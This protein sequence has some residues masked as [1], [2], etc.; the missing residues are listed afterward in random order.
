[1]PSY[2]S[3]G[4]VDDGVR[5]LL[6]VVRVIPPFLCRSSQIFLFRNYGDEYPPT[7]YVFGDELRG[8]LK[9]ITRA[10]RAAVLPAHGY[11][12]EYVVKA[13]GTGP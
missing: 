9:T 1:M 11:K 6:K 8:R 3:P 13:V 12:P 4:G 5:P 2:G 10:W 7:A